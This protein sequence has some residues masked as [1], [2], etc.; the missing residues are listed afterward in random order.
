MEVIKDTFG[1][2]NGETIYAY[3]LKND[4]GME[5]TSINYGCIITKMLVPDQNGKI[6][7]VV[8]GFDTVE[9]YIEH[10]PFFG[11]VIGRVAGRI[12]GASFEL[13]G[14][15]YDLA[16]NNG[17]NHLHGGLKGFDKVIWDTNVIEGD[18]SVGLE[19]TYFSPDG[20]EGYPGNLTV[21]VTY[22][23]DNNNVFTIAY[24]GV[25][26]ENTL[27]NLTNHTYF[28]LN[29]NL[30]DDILNH[31]LTL[32]SDK[33]I[34]LN[35]DLIPTGEFLDVEN[36]AFDFRQGREIKDG[37]I[38]TLKQNQLAGNGYDHPFVLSS[39]HNREIILEC[40]ESGRNLVVETDEPCVV[41]YTGNQMGDDFDMNGVPSRKHLGL[42]LETQKHPDAINQPNFDSIVLKKGESYKSQ[43]S[44]QFNVEL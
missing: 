37:T 9:E 18:D 7:N 41:L 4:K 19:F 13:D 32:K 39:N 20:E 26:D 33:F 43:T 31:V 8:L 16:V 14:K 22:T 30:K 23:L 34:E 27:L 36:T 38:S 35:D 28:N 40:P 3:T 6:E 21:K 1:Q 5:V 15:T 42:C 11:A 10:S 29:G 25:S 2:L 17:P 24:E 44:F 12:G